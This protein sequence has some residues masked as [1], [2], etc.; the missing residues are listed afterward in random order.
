MRI[1]FKNMAFSFWRS[2]HK[3]FP[4]DGTFRQYILM[5]LEQD[6]VLIITSESQDLPD[7]LNQVWQNL[8]P[9]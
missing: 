5:M 2:W 8:L 7:D 1:G 4:G 3:S 9:A 6:A